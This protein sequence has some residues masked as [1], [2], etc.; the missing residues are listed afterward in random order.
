MALDRTRYFLGSLDTASVSLDRLRVGGM[1]S[2]E[3][4]Y[5]SD[6]DESLM[7]VAASPLF[8]TSIF[9]FSSL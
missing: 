2:G 4:A 3:V 5:S 7:A 9:T 8:A 1:F 6:D